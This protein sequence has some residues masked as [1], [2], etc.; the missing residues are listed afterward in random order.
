[1]NVQCPICHEDF[2]EYKRPTILYTPPNVTAEDQVI[3]Y[4]AQCFFTHEATIVKPGGSYAIYQTVTLTSE[5]K[6]QTLATLAELFA[7]RVLTAPTEA[8]LRAEFLA[9]AL[10]CL[11][12]VV[13]RIEACPDAQL[14]F[15]LDAW[16]RE[17]RGE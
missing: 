11:G 10:T 4:C 6:K 9:L 5:R 17:G 2:P 14:E 12:R 8:E 1:M 15:L 16:T 7:A 13:A 3:K